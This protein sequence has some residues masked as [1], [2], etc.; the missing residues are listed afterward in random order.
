MLPKHTN[1]KFIYNTGCS[2]E[3]VKVCRYISVGMCIKGQLSDES[4][5]S[6]KLK[7]LF[8]FNVVGFPLCYNGSKPLNL[9]CIVN[10]CSLVP[11]LI[12]W[13]KSGKN[14]DLKEESRD[15]NQSLPHPSTLA[16]QLVS[17]KQHC[18]P[19]W[20]C[21]KILMQ[22]CFVLLESNA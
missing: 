5:H 6:V 22:N 18:L 20:K 16:T 15:L 14:W 7:F 17:S 3:G 11:A 13:E 9:I 2:R 1:S 12:S 8:P 10:E 21:S 4:L 19:K